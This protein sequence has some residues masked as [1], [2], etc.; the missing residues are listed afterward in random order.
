MGTLEVLETVP[1]QILRA[2]AQGLLVGLQDANGTLLTGVLHCT[3][4][5]LASTKGERPLRA[6]RRPT[7]CLV[8]CLPICGVV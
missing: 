4:D 8:C 3:E 7:G 1:A 2:Q 5:E 6:G